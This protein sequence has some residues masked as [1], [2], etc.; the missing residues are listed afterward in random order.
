M[1][2]I[3][4]LTLKTRHPILTD[5]SYCFARGCFYGIVATNGSGKT[6]F[7]RAIMG[8][9]PVEK[10]HFKLTE[11]PRGKRELFYFEDSDWFDTNLSGLDYLTFIQ[12]EWQSSV[13]IRRVIDI[14]AMSDYIKLPI[15]KY[16]LGMKQRLLI[17]LYLVSDANY[18]LMDE[19][20]NG[21]DEQSRGVIFSELQKLR[22]KGKM[23]IL[24]SH[25]KEDIMEYCDVM[26]SFKDEK[27]VE[28]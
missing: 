11:A 1:L 14:F 25:Y 19:I 28:V 13:D 15:K 24:T 6:T 21:L 7:F 12:K 2:V 5:Y 10:G 23:I 27:L 22:D 9:I 4:D 26:L 18:L 17:G 8:L 20:T 16:S 3:H